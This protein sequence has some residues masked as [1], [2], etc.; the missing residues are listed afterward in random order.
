MVSTPLHRGVDPLAGGQVTGHQ[1]D[2]I[3]G[4]AAVAAEHPDLAAGVPQP[5]DDLAAECS[6]AAGDQHG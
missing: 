6:G 3:P 1:L 4:L 5:R 2:A